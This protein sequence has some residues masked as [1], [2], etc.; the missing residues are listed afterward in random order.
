MLFTARVRGLLACSAWYTSPEVADKLVSGLDRGLDVSGA[1][2]EAG[3]PA[4][5][6]QDVW[7]IGVTLFEVV[8]GGSWLFSGVRE[9]I[10]SDES[11]DEG[12][13][14]A[15]QD[16]VSGRVGKLVFRAALIRPLLT[17]RV[18]RAGAPAPRGALPQRH[19]GAHSRERRQGV[20]CWSQPSQGD[21]GPAP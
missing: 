18:E 3:V 2:A 19:R 10:L 1:L 8:T 5:P 17:F 4:E 9:P 12:E 11:E 13:S 14:K 16:S 21:A 15:D 6:S 20:P 7:A